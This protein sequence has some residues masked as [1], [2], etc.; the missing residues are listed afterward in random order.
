MK[1][2]ILKMLERKKEELYTEIKAL[3]H[4]ATTANKLEFHTES[5]MINKEISIYN[6]FTYIVDEIIKIVHEI[7][8]E[9]E[10]ESNKQK[11]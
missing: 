9:N 5:Q 6:E 3:K 10:K 8:D 4:N 1:K 2:D 11:P 7:E